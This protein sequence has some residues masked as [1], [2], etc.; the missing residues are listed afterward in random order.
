MCGLLIPDNL[1]GLVVLGTPLGTPAF[2]GAFVDDKIDAES[3]FLEKVQNLQDIQCAW[4]MLSMSVVPRANHLIRMLP[5]SIS[6]FYAQRHDALLWSNFCKLF[7]AEDLQSDVLARDIASMPGRLGGLGLRSA[8]RSARG[9]YWASWVN[10]LPVI[11]AKYPRIAEA[12][13]SG[14]ET[15]NFEGVAPDVLVLEASGTGGSVHEAELIR[16]EGLAKGM[17]VPTW[18]EVLEGVLPPPP[19][20]GVDPSEFDRGWQCFYCSFVETIFRELSILPLCSNSRRALL[21][22]QSGGASS[23]FLRAIPSEAA[24]TI[25]PLRFQV[26]IRRRL[27]WPLPL[28]GG[29]CCRG[30]NQQM[31][32]YGDRAASCGTSGRI[33]LRSVP[34]EKIWARILREA[35]SFTVL[36]RLKQVV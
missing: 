4:V 16:I 21:L 13:I 29:I 7:Q 35:V 23:A 5:P 31:D 34:V 9:A 3:K 14:F 24:L 12:V 25:S 27:R 19:N 2:V 32:V 28:S 1:N 18:R 6:Q 11:H 20:E 15:G 22:S 36:R 33:K 8:V 10:A 17:A 26:A 30:C